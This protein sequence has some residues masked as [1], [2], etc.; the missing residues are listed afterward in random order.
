[1]S[2]Q[3]KSEIWVQA[4]IR[5]AQAQSGFVS[6]L[7]KGD[8]DAGIV[9]IILRKGGVQTLYTPERNFN[10]E[11][12]WLGFESSEQSR[13]DQ[14]INQRVDYDPDLWV[15]EIESDVKAETLIGEPIEAATKADD[16]VT[17]A[18]EALFRGG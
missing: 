9:L 18:A 2:Y 12:V 10:G 15:V 5:R 6:V 17:I 16:P 8:P 11:R 4:L 7:R 3:L 14:K 1:M 13:I